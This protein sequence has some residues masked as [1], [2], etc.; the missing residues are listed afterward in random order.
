MK[1]V[2]CNFPKKENTTAIAFLG[3]TPKLANQQIYR[4]PIHTCAFEI[5]SYIKPIVFI[6][7][8]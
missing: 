4:A 7:S 3:N 6:F 2:T 5:Q 1:V 8:L